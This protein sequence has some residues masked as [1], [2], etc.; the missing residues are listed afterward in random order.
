MQVVVQVLRLQSFGVQRLQVQQFAADALTVMQTL[1]PATNDK[2]MARPEPG[3]VRNS[4]VQMNDREQ[5]YGLEYNSVCSGEGEHSKC[6]PIQLGQIFCSLPDDDPIRRIR[7]ETLGEL[8]SLHLA[9]DVLIGHVRE[10]AGSENPSDA[11][12]LLKYVENPSPSPPSSRIDFFSLGKPISQNS[13]IQ[14]F[15]KMLSQAL[16]DVRAKK[17]YGKVRTVRST[18]AFFGDGRQKCSE[19]S[20]T[21]KW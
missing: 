19:K 1:A 17:L 13:Q 20:W 7:V 3:S 10:W 4:A 9:K 16:E 8:I 11:D 2:R 5:M 14:P 21:P 6:A 18:F 12:K 15:Q